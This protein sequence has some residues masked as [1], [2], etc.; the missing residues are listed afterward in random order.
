MGYAS[1]MSQPPLLTITARVVAIGDL[2]T[3][4]GE[5]AVE[6]EYDDPYVDPETDEDDIEVLTCTLPCS[7]EQAHALKAHLFS[8]ITLTIT[9]SPRPTH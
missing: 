7:Q 5:C 2:P 9:A 8:E 1:R 6:L 4:D 3:A